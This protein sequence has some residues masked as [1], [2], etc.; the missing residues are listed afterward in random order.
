MVGPFKGLSSNWLK[1][2]RASLTQSATLALETS[3]LLRRWGI[4]EIYQEQQA[5]I[6]LLCL[7]F[8]AVT[9]LGPLRVTAGGDELCCHCLVASDSLASPSEANFRHVSGPGS[10]K[11]P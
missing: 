2:G 11:V 7:P 3:F 1:A 4:V 9:L 5:L 10:Y 6:S 8:Y